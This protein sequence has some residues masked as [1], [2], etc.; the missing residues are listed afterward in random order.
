MVEVILE[1]KQQQQIR[2]HVP[3]TNQA[4]LGGELNK[5]TL[6]VKTSEYHHPHHP[7]RQQPTRWN[8]IN[9]K[10]GSTWKTHREA[11]LSTNN[12]ST[13]GNHKNQFPSQASEAT[14]RHSV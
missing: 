9:N 7:A 13:N 14:S 11:W 2:Q 12:T 8:N 3:N 10:D 5:D 6:L 1:D 4:P